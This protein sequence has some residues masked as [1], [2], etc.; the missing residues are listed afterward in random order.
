M[1]FIRKELTGYVAGRPGLR[2]VDIVQQLY[3]HISDALRAELSRT[4]RYDADQSFERLISKLP[5]LRQL[6]TQHLLL[7]NN[8]KRMVPQ[9]E[10]EIPPLHR[11]LFPLKLS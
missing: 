5:A 11:E 1:R 3:G 8:F 9:I 7:L 6:S 10:T 4:K 2:H